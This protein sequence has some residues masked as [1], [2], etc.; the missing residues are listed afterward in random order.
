[1][2]A[3]AATQEVLYLRQLLNDLKYPQLEA[4]VLMVDNQGAIGL[5]KSPVL[6]QRTKHRG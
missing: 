2:A 6:H 3:S 4:T 1:M 5:A